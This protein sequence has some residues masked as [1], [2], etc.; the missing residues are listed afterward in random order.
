MAT[1]GET[2]P[3]AYNEAALVY[4]NLSQPQHVPQQQTNQPA[5]VVQGQ[6]VYVGGQPMVVTPVSQV[7]PSAPVQT[8]A[9]V[10]TGTAV[11][12]AGETNAPVGTNVAIVDQL[13]NQ[14][15]VNTYQGCCSGP[16][17]ITG[18]TKSMAYYVGAL[19]ALIVFEIIGNAM[20]GVDEMAVIEFESYSIEYTYI[21]GMIDVEFEADYSGSTYRDIEEYDDLCDDYND[22]YD[23]DDDAFDW[24]TIES[25]GAWFAVFLAFSFISWVV[26]M[27]AVSI[28]VCCGPKGCCHCGDTCCQSCV[29]QSCCNGFCL[30]NTAV[31]GMVVV[32]IINFIG[33]LIWAVDN[34]LSDICDDY[35][36]DDCETSWGSTWWLTLLLGFAHVGIAAM[37]ASKETWKCM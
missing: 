30:K 15:H 12:A 6:I 16:S 28:V 4:P 22:Y 31:W 27:V 36:Y 8:V 3:P 5:Q 26:A 1:T 25:K 14:Q 10:G 11:P 19:I 37:L 35:D 17:G 20:E 29:Q 32:C 13:H 23:D 33:C 24:C 2:R 9:T 34:P 21:F 18:D 7:H